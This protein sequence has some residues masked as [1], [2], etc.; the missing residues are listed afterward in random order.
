M[1]KEW[2]FVNLQVC[3]ILKK[4]A[5]PLSPMPVIPKMKLQALIATG[6]TLGGAT[7]KTG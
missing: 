4:E 2:N 3:K 7:Y 5:N 6:Q 1:I